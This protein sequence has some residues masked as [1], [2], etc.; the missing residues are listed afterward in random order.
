MKNIEDKKSRI[1]AKY[2]FTESGFSLIDVVVSVAIM[3]ALSVGGFVVY[4]GLVNSAQE[5]AEE[6][7]KTVLVEEEK[8]QNQDEDQIYRR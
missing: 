5:A 3:V 7:K 8:L 2:T 1:K 4:T 6:S